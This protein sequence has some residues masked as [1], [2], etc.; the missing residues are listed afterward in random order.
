MPLRISN[1][2][3]TLSSSSL[4][5]HLQAKAFEI[6]VLALL[7]FAGSAAFQA[8]AQKAPHADRLTGVVVAVGVGIALQQPAPRT[9]FAAGVGLFLPALEDAGHRLQ[10]RAACL[11][12]LK[13]QAQFVRSLLHDDARQGADGLEETVFQSGSPPR[14]PQV[15]GDARRLERQAI[16]FDAHGSCPQQSARR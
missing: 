11:G 8:D 7:R 3:T 15:K 5:L 4:T 13:V 1:K 12:I 10:R 16:E 9:P 14:R 6:N 2:W